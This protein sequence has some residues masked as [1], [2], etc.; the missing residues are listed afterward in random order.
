MATEETS[1]EAEFIEMIGKIAQVSNT[2]DS[3]PAPAY[4]YKLGKISG[5]I[6]GYRDARTAVTPG[7]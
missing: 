2:P 7:K 3:L 1:P 6:S 5:Y 4:A